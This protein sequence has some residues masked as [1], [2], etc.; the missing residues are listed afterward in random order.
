MG[1]GAG[2]LVILG[3]GEGDLGDLPDEIDSIVPGLGKLLPSSLGFLTGGLRK[4]QKTATK[5]PKKKKVKKKKE[6]RS[7]I[8]SIKGFFGGGQDGGLEATKSAYQKREPGKS[9]TE[10]D[11][12]P[13]KGQMS[14]QG[15]HSRQPS[16]ELL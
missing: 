13:F 3:M 2:G 15:K 9:F 5:T 14:R 6:N 8:S 11:F 4:S 1:I 7:F 10:M 12:T 16:A